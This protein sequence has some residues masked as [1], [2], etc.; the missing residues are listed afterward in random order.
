MVNANANRDYRLQVDAEAMV[1]GRLPHLTGSGSEPGVCVLVMIQPSPRR[2][3]KL[4][5]P[6]A[7]KKIR[8]FGGHRREMVG[9]FRRSGW[10]RLRRERG[11][12]DLAICRVDHRLVYSSQ[13]LS[14]NVSR[15][16]TIWRS[17]NRLLREFQ[18]Y[19]ARTTSC[20]AAE[21]ISPI[22]Q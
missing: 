3:A 2:S 14:R 4:I 5:G 15:A 8:R 1:V 12:V 13:P 10:R 18:A 20:S 19:V 16:N 21:S 6:G 11:I 9:T 22:T 17:V 7:E